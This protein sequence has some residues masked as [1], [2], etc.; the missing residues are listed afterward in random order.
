[1]IHKIKASVAINRLY[2]EDAQELARQDNVS[3]SEYVSQAVAW[4]NGKHREAVKQQDRE[5]QK[6]ES[7][8]L[9]RQALEVETKKLEAANKSYQTKKHEQEEEA[10]PEIENQDKEMTAF[11][12]AKTLFKADFRPGVVYDWIK[13]SHE[14]LTP[15]EI[16]S[17]IN[18]AWEELHKQQRK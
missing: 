6:T 5:A 15:D 8:Q 18:K 13:N 16:R 12:M 3:M 1:M 10:K 2:W 11:E 4:Y 14:D 17:E 7:L 9:K